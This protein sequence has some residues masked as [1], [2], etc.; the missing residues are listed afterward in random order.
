MAEIILLS[1]V[2]GDQNR[3]H[4]FGHCHPKFEMVKVWRLNKAIPSPTFIATAL[5]GDG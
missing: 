1:G 3:A 2:G 4:A 5:V